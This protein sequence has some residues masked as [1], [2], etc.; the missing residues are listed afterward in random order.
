MSVK[1][2]LREACAL[3]QRS[4][5]APPPGRPLLAVD[6][7]GGRC[8]PLSPAAV[9]WTSVG[10]LYVVDPLRL[11]DRDTHGEDGL[12]AYELLAEAARQ[13]G[14]PCVL[15]ADTAGVGVAVRMFWQAES[16]AESEGHARRR[17]GRASAAGT[18]PKG[19][20]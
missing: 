6:K 11:P 7:D 12:Q 5:V 16:L 10:A 19:A 8:E 13:Q 17:G 1:R 4:H 9:A 3:I 15:A 18:T 14:H 2:V 20:A